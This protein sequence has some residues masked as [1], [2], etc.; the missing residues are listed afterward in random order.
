VEVNQYL[1]LVKLKYFLSAAAVVSI[2]LIAG[3]LIIS[4]SEHKHPKKEPLTKFCLGISDDANDLMQNGE[5]K[6]AYTV[7]KDN[8]KKCGNTQNSTFNV[9]YYAKL[10]VSS[11]E[12]GNK[13]AAKTYAK[14][15]ISE[16]DKLKGADQFK[17]VNF[18][19][20]MMDMQK[21]TQGK[22]TGLGFVE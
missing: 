2:L 8:E 19:N 10:S 11:Y 20:L 1:K 15:T 17:I 22:Y 21:I 9:L 12:E 14:Y 6:K 5:Q 7:L 4:K 18:V 3:V 13:T 16:G